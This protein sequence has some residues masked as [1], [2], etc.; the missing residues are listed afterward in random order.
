MKHEFNWLAV[1]HPTYS[2]LLKNCLN[3]PFQ[4]FFQKF[5]SFIEKKKNIYTS[6]FYNRNNRKHLIT[7]VK[8]KKGIFFIKD[9]EITHGKINTIYSV[10]CNNI[11]KRSAIESL[12]WFGNNETSIIIGHKKVA[13]KLKRDNSKMISIHYENHRL[14]LAM[15]L[16]SKKVHFLKKKKIII[17]C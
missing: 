13:S 9:I 10:L 11:E 14:S 3:P 4:L 16:S 6:I 12:G 5:H 17:I 1:L 8:L 7:T 15:L 2:F